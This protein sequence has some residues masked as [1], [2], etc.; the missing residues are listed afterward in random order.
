MEQSAATA[1]P[2]GEPIVLML[3]MRDDICPSLSHWTITIPR[4]PSSFL[5]Q[6]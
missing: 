6:H 5:E 3:Q 1:S 4:C 2:G